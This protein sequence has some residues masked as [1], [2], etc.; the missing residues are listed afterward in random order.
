MA[1][2]QIQHL[3]LELVIA[4]PQVRKTFDQE[5]QEGIVA[6]LKEVGQLQPVRVRPEGKQFVIVDG[7]RRYRAIRMLAWPTIAAI[8][9]ANNL[10]AGEILQKQLISNC[11]REDL[12][13][14][15]KAMAI[16]KPWRS[17]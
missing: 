11:Q 15:E 2:E 10:N 17:K 14:L 5:S 7:E 13:A 4:Q 16:Y 8:V 12:T 6:S 3:P 1:S 9:E